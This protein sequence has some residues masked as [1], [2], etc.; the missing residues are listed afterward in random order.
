MVESGGPAL[1]LDD[2]VH[3][4]KSGLQIGPVSLNLQV[5]ECLGLMGPNGAGKTTLMRVLLGLEPLTEGRARLFGQDVRYGEPPLRASGMLEEPRFF[6]W[7][8]AGDNLRAAVPGRRLQR[9][10]VTEL[11]VLVGLESV[12]NRPVA[13]FSQGMRQRLAL[14]RVL[15]VE[16]DL[17]VLDEPTNGLDPAG[18]MWLRGLIRE[19]KVEGRSVLLS[20][21]LLHEV[22]QVADLYVMIDRGRAIASGN[23]SDLTH[24]SSLEDLYFSLKQSDEP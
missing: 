14:A 9:D 22:Q 13:R 4:F 20:S 12:G 8:N 2:V 19:L 21:H 16:P 17:V 3:R 10:R 24:V 5:G 18:I 23:V 15:L 11:L 6:G 1:E 7:L